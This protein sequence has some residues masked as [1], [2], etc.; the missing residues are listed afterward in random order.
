MGKN[1]TYT[2]LVVDDEET[3]L[4]L[5]GTILQ[6]KKH[7]VQ[8]ALSVKEALQKIDKENFDMIFSDLMMPHIDGIDFFKELRKNDIQTPFVI[9]TAFDDPEKIQE[10]ILLGIEEYIYKPIER[11]EIFSILERRLAST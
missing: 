9:M 8:Y 6:K 2:I 1:S 3:N 11:E 5:V 7:N 10:A 4:N